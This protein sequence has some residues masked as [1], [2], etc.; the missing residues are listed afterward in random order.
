M[1]SLLFICNNISSLFLDNKESAQKIKIAIK[2]DNVDW[3][4]IISLASGWLVLP[5]LYD[6]LE[7]FQLWDD[8]PEDIYLYLKT[9]HEL[10]E[11]RTNKT[12]ID[13]KIIYSYL[14]EK[15]IPVIAIKGA[16]YH[17]NNLYSGVTFRI[18]SDIDL[19]IPNN[20]LT[21]AYSLLKQNGFL[22]P[23]KYEK[24]WVKR[25]VSHHLPALMDASGAE[26]E[27]HQEL[28]PREID[29][30]LTS[31]EVWDQAIPHSNYPYS[32][33]PTHM[34]MLILIHSMLVDVN[35]CAS[36]FNLRVVQD[37]LLIRQQYENDI[38][39]LFILKRF[40]AV[41]LEHIPS[42]Y[43]Q[44]IEYFLGMQSPVV[45]KKTWRTTLFVQGIRFNH[46]FGYAMP[47]LNHFI[48]PAK[49]RYCREKEIFG[50]LIR[51]Y[52]VRVQNK[53]WR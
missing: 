52:W 50:K 14:K 8:I 48:F 10:S 4:S 3:K 30:L 27:I 6:N 1:N 18:E 45:F 36:L 16:A 41:H 51:A 12:Q 42:A 31:S 19:L 44:A 35:Y 17:V 11:E 20:Y 5:V 34:M 37:T 47:R 15:N 53:I 9:V 13:I 46:Y 43:F 38:D 21:L 49:M 26:V 2:Q 22:V 40:K 33:S 7:K 28:Y 32:P 25:P 29:I 24:Q 23:E 39:W